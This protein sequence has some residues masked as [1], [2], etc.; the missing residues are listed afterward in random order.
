MFQYSAIQTGQTTVTGTATLIYAAYPSRSGI[1]LTNTGGTTTYIG[2]NSGV[3]T[4]TG[5]PLV[6]GASVS[7]QTTGAIYGIT[8]G[9]SNLIGWLQT[10]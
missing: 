4:V 3:T 8:G 10:N 5:Y 9:G 1:V 7:F 2:E 6:A